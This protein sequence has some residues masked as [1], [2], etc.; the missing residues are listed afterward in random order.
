MLDDTAQVL[1]DQKDVIAY[2]G[3]GSNDP[4]RHQRFLGF[5]WLPGAIMTEFVSTDGRTFQM[6]PQNWT[7]GNWNGQNSWFAGSPQ[8]LSADYIHEG[9]TGAAGHVAEPYLGFTPRPDLLLPAYYSGRTLAESY[10]LSIRALS[11]QNIVIGD[12]LCSLG[13]P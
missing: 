2:A 11:W 9:A 12:P 13:K 3:W 10:Y 6:P 5:T 4:A 8:S 1:L 7:L